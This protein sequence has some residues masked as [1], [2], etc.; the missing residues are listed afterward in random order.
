MGETNSREMIRHMFA[1]GKVYWDPQ[2]RFWRPQSVCFCTSSHFVFFVFS[3]T[4]SSH[5]QAGR[6]LP[7][8]SLIPPSCSRLSSKASICI[9]N[10][11]EKWLPSQ[12]LSPCLADKQGI[13]VDVTQTKYIWLQMPSSCLCHRVRGSEKVLRNTTNSLFELMTSKHPFF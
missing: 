10:T 13:S 12:L 5:R 11:L 9:L 8:P 2:G 3:L 7:P 4:P 6:P 1:V